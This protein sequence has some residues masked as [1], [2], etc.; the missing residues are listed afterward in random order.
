MKNKLYPKVLGVALGALLTGTVGALAQTTT[1]QNAAPARTEAQAATPNQQGNQMCPMMKG[2]GGSGMNM[3]MMNM[4]MDCCKKMGM[5]M[6]QGMNMERP[7]AGGT[8]DAGR[9]PRSKQ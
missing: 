6:G 5:N 1:Q 9:R 2:E 4:M 7:A 3:S 8:N